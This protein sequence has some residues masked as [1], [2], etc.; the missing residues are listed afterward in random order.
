[1]AL[2]GGSVRE[3]VVWTGSEGFHQSV[4]N[5]WLTGIFSWAGALEVGNFRVLHT[6]VW[7]NWIGFLYT[8]LSSKQA[9]CPPPAFS[10]KTLFIYSVFSIFINGLV[11][12]EKN[13]F[14]FSYRSTCTLILVPIT[15]PF[16]LTLVLS[17]H[18][19]FIYYLDSG[20][21][22]KHTVSVRD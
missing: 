16:P 18:P 22:R 10:F 7:V 19:T 17:S 9:V 15:F 14:M 4:L 13:G 20:C 1:M 6:K 12:L 5:A 2:L 3:A 21:E 8:P 11:S